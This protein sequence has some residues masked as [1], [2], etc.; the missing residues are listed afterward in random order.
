MHVSFLEF[1]NG[2]V[3]RGGLARSFM[4]LWDTN[5]IIDFTVKRRATRLAIERFMVWAPLVPIA[6]LMSHMSAAYVWLPFAKESIMALY[7]NI[8]LRKLAKCTENCEW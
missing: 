7:L 8:I 3:E 6:W 4:S 2:S 1:E 5:A